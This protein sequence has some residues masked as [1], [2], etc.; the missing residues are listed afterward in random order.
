MKNLPTETRQFKY[1]TR[2]IQLD[3]QLHNIAIMEHVLWS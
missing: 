2:E 1:N 3:M